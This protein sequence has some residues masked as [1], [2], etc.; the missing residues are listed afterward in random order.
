ALNPRMKLF[1]SRS[2][3]EIAPQSVRELAVNHLNSIDWAVYRVER[4]YQG[5]QIS[6]RVKKVS[7]P[8]PRHVANAQVSVIA[9]HH[10][11]ACDT[12][13]P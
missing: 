13:D 7:E 10:G 2:A 4:I 3:W 5:K 11:C 6:R 8:M 9:R 12:S 1:A